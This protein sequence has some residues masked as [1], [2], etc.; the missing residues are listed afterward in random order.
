M[1]QYETPEARPQ[2][3]SRLGL[4]LPAILFVSLA[5]AWSAFWVYATNKADERL[6][7]WLQAEKAAGHSFEC[8][9][10][11]MGGFPFRI[12]LTCASL[13]YVGP[14]LHVDMGALHTATQIYSPKITLIDVSG[15]LLIESAGVRTSL[16]WKDM[17]LSLRLNQ[18]LERLSLSVSEL[19]ADATMEVAFS[20]KSAEFHLRTDTD[21]PAEERAADFVLRL[22]GANIEALDQ[23]FGNHD[24]VALDI[25]GTATKILGLRAGPWQGLVEDWRTINGRLL[26]ENGR[27]AKGNFSFEGKGAFDIDSAHR[28]RGELAVAT[29]G[30][31]PLVAR[32]VP[33]NA[34]LLAG[35]ILERKDGTPVQLPLRLQEGRMSLGPI[36]TGPILRPLY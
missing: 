4:Y 27:I 28:L 30:I 11:N 25:T 3:V 17:R 36:R 19:K 9:G 29:K 13:K 26:L 5:L 15:P 8:A 10:K 6:I 22:N 32:L 24:P 16:D 34:A 1:S 18:G 21:Q 35:A 23:L 31:A 14:N 33:G 20:A 12:E 7:Q 2:V